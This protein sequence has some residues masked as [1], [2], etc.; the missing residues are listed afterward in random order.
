MGNPFDNAK[1]RYVV[2]A[3][4]GDATA[5]FSLALR[6]AHGNDVTQSDEEAVY[7]YEK[8]AEQGHIDAQF[9]LTICYQNGK[10][11]TQSY[12]KVAY[13]SE[14]AAE[15][16]DGDAQYNLGVCYALGQGVTKSTIL[17]STYYLLSARQGHVHAQKQL[18]ILVKEKVKT[19]MGAPE[20][21]EDLQKKGELLFELTDSLLNIGSVLDT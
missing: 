6:Y 16:G 15:Q 2:A 4:K 5:Q 21:I 11:V 18:F 3:E 19:V 12:E 10:G 9:N 17:A 7:W 13:W 14:K 20:Y 1:P 8:A